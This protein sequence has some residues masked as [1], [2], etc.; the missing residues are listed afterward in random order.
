MFIVAGGRH[1]QQ[2]HESNRGHQPLQGACPP[3][4]RRP[5]APNG[6]CGVG[7]RL[8]FTGAPQ[9]RRRATVDGVRVTLRPPLGDEGTCEPQVGTWLM[10][11]ALR[12]ATCTWQSSGAKGPWVE[13]YVMRKGERRTAAI[14][15]IAAHLPAGGLADEDLAGELGA[16]TAAKIFD[17]TGIRSTRGSAPAGGARGLGVWGA[18]R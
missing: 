16:W 15:A 7:L 18:P 6:F 12:Y 5:D 10:S 1:A 14:A 8:R 2:L 9:C 4:P 3:T 11:S 17:K 13:E